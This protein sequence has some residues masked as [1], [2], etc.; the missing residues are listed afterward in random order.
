MEISGNLLSKENFWRHKFTKSLN[1]RGRLALCFVMFCVGDKNQIVIEDMSLFCG[2]ESSEC[3]DWL[4]HFMQQGYL[5][6][7]MRWS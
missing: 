5:R 4:D 2:I 3:E 1:I 7:E 6:P